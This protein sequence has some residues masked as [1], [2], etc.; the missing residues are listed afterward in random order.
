MKSAT[1]IM[2]S[3]LA[4]L[5][6]ACS[7]RQASVVH[8]SPVVKRIEALDSAYGRA[9]VSLLNCE[10][11]VDV[12]LA[13]SYINMQRGGAGI[14]PGYAVKD[15]RVV[16]ISDPVIINVYSNF[17]DALTAYIASHG[18]RDGQ[19][20]STLTGPLGGY[21]LRHGKLR[22]IAGHLASACQAALKGATSP[23]PLS[24]YPTPAAEAK[25]PPGCPGSAALLAAWHAASASAIRAQGAGP[26]LQVSGFM[27]ISCWQGWVVAD[28]ITNAN[29]SAEFG[30]SG[31][32]QL[33]SGGELQ[34]FNTAVCD[35]PNSPSDWKGAAAGPAVCP[36]PEQPGYEDALAVWNATSGIYGFPV[37]SYLLRA[38]DDLRAASNSAATSNAYAPAINDLTSLA[39]LP[40]AGGTSAQQ[41]EAKADV[42]WLDGFF[43]TPGLTPCLAQAGCPGPRT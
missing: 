37:A 28:L 9:H 12:T 41:A 30:S 1:A 13:V 32:L 22:Y 34:Q 8:L 16:A 21:V 25:G 19:A 31:G 29:G 38:A 15:G 35:S 6:V 27:D 10:V 36:P 33:L 4:V 24:P 3:S 17:Y 14:P 11:T 43:D 2:I 7:A 26:G 23:A 40:T 39:S 5:A 18:T 42:T 20:V